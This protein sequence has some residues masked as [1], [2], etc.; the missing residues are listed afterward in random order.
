MRSD[1]KGLM[2][3]FAHGGANEGGRAD[4]GGGRR[5]GLWEPRFTSPRGHLGNILCVFLYYDRLLVKATASWGQVNVAAV[6]LRN[7]KAGAVGRCLES[8]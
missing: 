3:L 4:D 5:R 2:S 8:G 1:T 7:R 6:A